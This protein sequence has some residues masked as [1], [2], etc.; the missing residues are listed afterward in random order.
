MSGLE[1]FGGGGGYNFNPGAVLSQLGLGHYAVEEV[2]TV[3]KLNCGKFDFIT[4]S[5]GHPWKDYNGDDVED[6]VALADNGGDAHLRI[7]SMEEYD[8]LLSLLISA[9]EA[10]LVHLA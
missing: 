7:T 5:S 2:S 8:Q 10:A 4:A 6:G 3:K 1:G 9:R